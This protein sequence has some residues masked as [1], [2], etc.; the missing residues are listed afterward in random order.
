[1]GDT[2]EAGAKGS[3]AATQQKGQRQRQKKGKDKEI[4]KPTVALSAAGR[5]I[6]QF[7]HNLNNTAANDNTH[8][9]SPAAASSSSSSSSTSSSSVGSATE[10][11]PRFVL[12]GFL[13]SGVVDFFFSSSGL[14]TSQV[15]KPLRSQPTRVRHLRRR[16]LLRRPLPFPSLCLVQCHHLRLLL[17]ERWLLGLCCGPRW[18]LTLLGLQPCPMIPLQGTTG[19]CLPPQRNELCPRVFM[20]PSWALSQHD[21]GFQKHRYSASRMMR[22]LQHSPRWP[23]RSTPVPMKRPRK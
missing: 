23:F 13:S 7:W 22:E 10:E 9:P 1:M 14:T 17:L 19:R 15:T 16:S 2:D 3:V 18:G 4:P 11:T 20:L 5:K 6:Q 12:F 8:T 21:L